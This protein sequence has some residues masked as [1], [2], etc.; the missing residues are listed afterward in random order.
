[1]SDTFRHVSEYGQTRLTDNLGNGIA[2]F[3]NQCYLNI[4]AYTNVTT[5]MSNPYGGDFSQLR[6]VDDPNYAAQVWEGA[7]SNWVFERDVRYAA[8]LFI[9]GIHIGA[10]FVTSGFYVDYPLGRV[11]LEDAIDPSTVVRCEHS[12][13]NVN[14]YTNEVPWFREFMQDSFRPDV[15]FLQ[16]GSGIWHT[17]GQN[18]VQLPAVIVQP[19]SAVKLIGIQLGGQNKRLQDVLIHVFAEHPWEKNSIADDLINQKDAIFLIMDRDR[20]NESGVYPLDM[21][22]SISPN[23]LSYTSLINDTAYVYS[24][25]D[26]K[27]TS[28][29]EFVQYGGLYYAA[30]T[31]T[32]DTY[33]G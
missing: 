30:V 16:R 14:V 18:R 21:N 22:G 27:N 8:P 23:G 28:A 24:R 12:Y 2:Q 19:L 15:Q 4:G 26:I 20:V 11:V 32:V 10:S 9:S 17:L 29:R 5:G 7:R 33:I 25:C 3:I 1:M 13:K 31:W 6:P